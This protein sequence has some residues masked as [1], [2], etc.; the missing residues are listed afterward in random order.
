MIRFS[1]ASLDIVYPAGAVAFL[2]LSMTILGLHAGTLALSVSLIA[3]LLAVGNLV[4]W[5]QTRE[6]AMLWWAAGGVTI[7]AAAAIPQLRAEAVLLGYLLIA[8][9]L[10]FY[11]IGIQSF[12]RRALQPARI[13]LAAGVCAVVFLG[14]AAGGP[15]SDH[16]RVSIV[17]VLIASLS[18]A[19]A[20][21]LLTQH[22][23]VARDASRFVGALFSLN[24]LVFVLFSQY[25]PAP[26]ADA[27]LPDALHLATYAAVLTLVIGWNFGFV[28]MVMQR[29]L[30]LAIELAT[31]DDLTGVLNRRAF[32]DRALQHLKLAERSGS[33]LSVLAMD[34]DHFKR[35]NDAHGHQAGDTVLREFVRIAQSCLRYPDQLGR[36]GGEEFVAILPATRAPGALIVAERLRQKLAETPIRHG[37]KSISLSV[38]IGVAQYDSRRHD[39]DT[40]LAAAD[41]ALYGAKHRGRNCVE[42]APGG[43]DGFPSVQLTWD[44]QYNSGHALIDAEHESLFVLVNQLVRNTQEHADARALCESLKEMLFWLSEHFRHEEAVFVAAGW[45]GADEHMRLHRELEARGQELLS[46]IGDGSR[47]FGDLFDFLIRDVVGIHLAQHDAAYFPVVAE[48]G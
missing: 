25:A 4:V 20:Y 18:A 43:S 2:G 29:Y 8:L 31:H 12:Q 35:V 9:T 6:Q 1:A 27:A 48:R 14:F 30:D 44:G 17:A 22:R 11:W 34:L 36:I 7:A 24:S 28:M 40:L 21:E 38:S 13:A 47:A 46:G 39:L 26:A 37:D 3:A 41:A 33:T 16:Y 10:C 32:S 45:S 19:C 23:S 5:R 42:L 15:A